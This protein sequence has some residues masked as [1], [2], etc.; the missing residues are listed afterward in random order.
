GLGKLWPNGLFGQ[1]RLRRYRFGKQRP[2]NRKLF[3]GIIRHLSQWE[4]IGV[5]VE[6]LNSI[7]PGPSLDKQQHLTERA[8]LARSTTSH[9]LITKLLSRY[10]KPIAY[11]GFCEKLPTSQFVTPCRGLFG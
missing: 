4:D 6:L 5:T 10:Q 8:F 11:D 9:R 1:Q 7:N 2:T 3:I